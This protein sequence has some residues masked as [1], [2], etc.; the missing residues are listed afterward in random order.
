MNKHNKKVLAE[1]LRK[2]I[3]ETDEMFKNGDSKD[4]I[5][6]YLKGTINVAIETLES[7]QYL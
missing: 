4:W 3:V 2:Q 7:D 6:G 5:I 1:M